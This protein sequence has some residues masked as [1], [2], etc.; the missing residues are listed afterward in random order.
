MT[1]RGQTMATQH[2]Y[3]I[4]INPTSQRQMARF[5]S[6]CNMLDISCVVG[7]EQL[8]Q[9]GGMRCI[10]HVDMLDAYGLLK[11]LSETGTDFSFYPIRNQD[12]KQAI[13]EI[14]AAYTYV[15]QRGEFVGM[16]V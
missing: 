3:A 1:E 12:A 6:E 4:L 15:V 9:V 13:R 10:A 2:Y 16:E 7:F 11:V 5:L 8:E 14:V